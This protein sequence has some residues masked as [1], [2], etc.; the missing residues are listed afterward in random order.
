MKK[1]FYSLLSDSNKVSSK[2]FIG[3]I[4][5]IMFVCY[6]IKGLIGP[7]NLNFSIFYVSLCTITIWVSFKFMSSDKLLKYNIIGQLSGFGNIKEDIKTV[8]ESEK[9]FD[10]AVQPT[11]EKIN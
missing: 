11:E 2:R 5:L 3:F 10:E 1:F 4:T 7:F 6:G 9:I 8:I